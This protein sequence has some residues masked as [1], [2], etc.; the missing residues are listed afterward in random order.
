MHNKTTHNNIILELSNNQ[1]NHINKLWASQLEHLFR[2]DK[3]YL[4]ESYAKDI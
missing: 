4:N 3:L 2:T 1:R